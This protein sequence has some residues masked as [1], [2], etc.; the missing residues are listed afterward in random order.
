LKVELHRAALAELTHGV[1]WYER[2]YPGRGVRFRIAV[3]RVLTRIGTAPLANGE[4]LGMRA[5]SVSRFP[6]VVFYSVVDVQTVRVIAIA[7][8]KRK[9][10]Y[11]A[12]R[13]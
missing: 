12:A 1:E 5:A 4:R 13:K 6:Y 10:N 9:P 3:D 8:T 2:D 7:H 11:W